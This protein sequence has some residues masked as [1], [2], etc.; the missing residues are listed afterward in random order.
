[1]ALFFLS[2]LESSFFFNN[3]PPFP[4]NQRTKPNI[5]KPWLRG[6]DVLTQVVLLR[7]YVGPGT[8]T[9]YRRGYFIYLSKENKRRGR[10]NRRL[11]D[12]PVCTQSKFLPPA[13]LHPPI[14]YL[15]EKRK[16]RGDVKRV[17]GIKEEEKKR[18]K[19]HQHQQRRG[20][21]G[22]EK[23]TKKEE[24]EKAKKVKSKKRKKE[25]GKK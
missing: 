6:V 18:K 25:K 17:E 7:S 13:C 2:L 20:G 23:E 21:K 11:L 12:D 14:S 5:A 4:K 8:R 16:P 10:K 3:P 24:K 9:P 22:K 1:M 15:S 19:N